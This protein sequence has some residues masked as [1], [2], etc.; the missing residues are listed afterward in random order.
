MNEY[1]ENEHTLFTLRLILTARSTE[2]EKHK[3]IYHWRKTVYVGMCTKES[4]GIDRGGPLIA[5]TDENR[6]PISK[7]HRSRTIVSEYREDF[8]SEILLLTVR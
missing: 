6:W 1:A 7:I 3:G 8:L 2:V 4:A 5:V